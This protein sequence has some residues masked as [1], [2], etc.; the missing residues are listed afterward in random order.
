MAAQLQCCMNMAGTDRL[1]I[2]WLLSHSLKS[3]QIQP[4]QTITGFIQ[5]QHGNPSEH[6]LLE[7]S[8]G[9]SNTPAVQQQH[10]GRKEEQKASLC[11]AACWECLQ[12]GCYGLDE[13]CAVNHP[14]QISL[15]KFTHSAGMCH[16]CCHYTPM[17]P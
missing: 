4:L 10:L 17:K 11:S 12:S 14:G 8:P 6:G 13:A 1:K 5:N 16:W 9:A 15:C 2:V 3:E 7:H